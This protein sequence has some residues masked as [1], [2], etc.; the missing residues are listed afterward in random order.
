[1][2]IVEEYDATAGAELRLQ[3]EKLVDKVLGFCDTERRDS[4]RKR[5]HCRVICSGDHQATT[6]GLPDHSERRVKTLPS[7]RTIVNTLKNVS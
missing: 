3:A 7:V 1:M 2:G 4:L 6:R 5:K